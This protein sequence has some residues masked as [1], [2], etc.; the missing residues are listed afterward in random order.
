MSYKKLIAV[1]IALTVCALTGSNVM[2]HGG[3]GG[4]HGGGF[5]GGFD[6]GFGG[7]GFRGGGLPVVVFEE[8]AFAADLVVAPFTAAAPSVEPVLT[9]AAFA[10][11]FVVVVFAEIGSTTT[12]S[13]IGLSSLA[14]FLTRSF[15]I[16]MAITITVTDTSL[17][18]S[19]FTKV[20]W[21]TATLWLEK[22]SSVWR[23]QAIIMA[24]SMA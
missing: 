6:G 8:E 7:G 20:G 12:I 24:R 4:G 19:L 9:V 16:P 22:S 2:A 18:M 21:D 3:G 15:T 10:V 11:A 5:D 23:V 13:M 14:I 17:T 1:T